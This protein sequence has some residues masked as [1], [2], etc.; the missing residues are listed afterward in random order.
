MT[1]WYRAYSGTVRDDKLAECAA[2]AECSRV[3][4]IATWHAILESA[5]DAADG[6]RFETTPRRV[7]ALFAEPVKTI[8]AI[9]AAMEEVGLIE[10]G[11]IPAWRKRQFESDNSTE[12]SRKHRAAKRNGD[13]T[14]QGR[15]ATPPEAETETENNLEHVELEGCARAPA[16]QPIVIDESQEPLR[17]RIA[18]AKLF[19]DAKSLPPDTGRVA[20][21]LDRGYTGREIEAVVADKLSR[22]R[23]PSSLSYFDAALADVRKIA[24]ASAKPAEKAIPDAA[25]RGWVEAWRRSGGHQWPPRE[26][27]VGPPPDRPGTRVPSAILAEFTIPPAQR[28]AA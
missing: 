5:A 23:V 2:I 20:I 15:C 22:G 6:G 28:T 26:S 1:R 27:G 16:D 4:V 13:A 18:V 17:T 10:D 11:I 3:A 7:A 9:F 8:E 24:P 19:E 12:R 25:W 14:L 21:W